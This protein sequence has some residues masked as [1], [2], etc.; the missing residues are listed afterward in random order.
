[1][2][3]PSARWDSTAWAP[4]PTPGTRP[5]RGCSRGSG[6]SA[7][8]CSARPTTISGSG[9]TARCGDCSLGLHQHPDEIREPGALVIA[10]A[11][12]IGRVLGDEALH[13]VGGADELAA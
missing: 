8:E 12:E 9:P 10:V 13:V 4:T 7:R 11:A 1:S 6:S 5:R 3:S 2:I